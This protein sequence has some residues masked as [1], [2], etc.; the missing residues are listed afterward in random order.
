MSISP[1]VLLERLV[2]HPQIIEDLAK[3]GPRRVW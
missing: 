2:A 1:P 3:R